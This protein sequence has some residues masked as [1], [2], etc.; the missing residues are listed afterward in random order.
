MVIALQG[1][2]WW[3][4]I[5]AASHLSHTSFSPNYT[6]EY[7]C[8]SDPSSADESMHLPLLSRLGD[9]CVKYHTTQAECVLAILSFK[10]P[11]EGSSHPCRP[12]SWPIPQTHST[13]TAIWILLSHCGDRP[14]CW[15]QGTEKSGGSSQQHINKTLVQKGKIDQVNLGNAKQGHTRSLWKTPPVQQHIHLG[16]PIHQVDKASNL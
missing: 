16:A 1:A 14:T 11:S 12:P 3:A 13:T 9:G 10:I 15:A 4:F 5:S 8:N 7:V 2:H 6:D